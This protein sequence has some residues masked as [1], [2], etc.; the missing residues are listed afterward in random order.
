MT[1]L[2]SMR[3]DLPV[4]FFSWPL[5]R[6]GI[7]SKTLVIFL[8][9]V[10][11]SGKTTLGRALAS[12]QDWRFVDADD[13][14]SAKNIKKMRSGHPLS[15]E[16]R[17]PWLRRLRGEIQSK[18]VLSN[19]TIVVACSALKTEYRQY[20]SGSGEDYHARWFIFEPVENVIVERL[21]DRTGHY[22]GAQMAASQLSVF[23]PPIDPEEWLSI[24]SPIPMLIQHI[25][26]R[27]ASD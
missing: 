3:I 14:H 24:E 19:V 6:N 1:Q 4:D 23:E 25:L 16:D 11:A 12:A 10:A 17:W 20:L 26:G 18:C 15:D 8:A 21:K 9:G 22:M 2:G 7:L 13:Y 5:L 27:L